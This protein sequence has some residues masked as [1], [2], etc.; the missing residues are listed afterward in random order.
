MRWG[1]GPHDSEAHAVAGVEDLSVD[2]D[3]VRDHTRVEP[4]LVEHPHELRTLHR[5][6]SDRSHPDRH[7]LRCSWTC[8]RLDTLPSGDR[9]SHR[10]LSSTGSANLARSNRARRSAQM[11]R[12]ITRGRR[13]RKATA[14][15]TTPGAT[16]PAI[17]WPSRCCRSA[18]NRGAVTSG[19]RA[20]MAQMARPRFRLATD[21]GGRGQQTSV[22]RC[23]T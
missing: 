23:P 12:R 9:W 16:R 3:G 22:V 2:D 8:R 1:N 19:W 11:R 6:H 17:F 18:A 14:P 7:V 4:G 21:L 10:H 20:S 13:P 15:A 5:I